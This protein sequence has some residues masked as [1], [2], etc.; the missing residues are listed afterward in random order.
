MC[1]GAMVQSRLGKCV[2]GSMSDKSG[3]AGSIINLLEEKG[4]NHQVQVES[5]VLREECSR[6]LTEFFGQMRRE[7]N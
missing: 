4:F 3:C 1:A 2:I 7:K 5:G 6:I